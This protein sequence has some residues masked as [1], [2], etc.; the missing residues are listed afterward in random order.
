MIIRLVN[1]PLKAEA[2]NFVNTESLNGRYAL[3]LF[4]LN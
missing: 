4:S 3:G 2:N 1:L